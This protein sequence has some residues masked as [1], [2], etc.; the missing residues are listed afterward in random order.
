VST[1]PSPCA[2][3]PVQFLPAMI[4]KSLDKGQKN[5]VCKQENHLK[6]KNKKSKKTK[7]KSSTQKR[8]LGSL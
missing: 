5:C 2:Q 3:D 6:I 7:D 1:T 8:R 4:Q